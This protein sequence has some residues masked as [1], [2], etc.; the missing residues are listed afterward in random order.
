M[1]SK[2]AS[3]TD[4]LAVMKSQF[5]VEHFTSETPLLDARKLMTACTDSAAGATS[6][7]TSARVRCRPACE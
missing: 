2:F 4:T 6:S 3:A 7:F 5:A 1:M